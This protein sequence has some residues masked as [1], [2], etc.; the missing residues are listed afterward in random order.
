M[1][2]MAGKTQQVIALPDQFSALQPWLEEWALSSQAARYARRRSSD[3]AT[4]KQFY[5]TVL[6]HMDEIVG[7]LEQRRTDSEH[8]VDQALL[9]LALMFIEVSMAI[10]L[11]HE[12]DEQRA[13]P[14]HRFQIIE[15]PHVPSEM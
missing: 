1:T 5:D 14:A 2:A 3:M 12:P 4:L 10:E 9:N 6:P 11:F 8:T 7:Y 13:M 15:G